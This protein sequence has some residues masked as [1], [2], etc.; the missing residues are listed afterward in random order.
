MRGLWRP[1]TWTANASE[2]TRYVLTDE[3]S[4]VNPSAIPGVQIAFVR[5]VRFENY[6]AV[7][8]MGD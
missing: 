1:E 8:V 2:V 7:K 6:R 5:L 3:L 4:T